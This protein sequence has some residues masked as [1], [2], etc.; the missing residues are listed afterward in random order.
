MAQVFRSNR[1]ETE[2]LA[3]CQTTNIFSCLFDCF[4]DDVQ[5]LLNGVFSVSVVLKK[6]KNKL[7]FIFL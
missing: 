4:I 1:T 3:A 5:M 7:F 6:V 2:S